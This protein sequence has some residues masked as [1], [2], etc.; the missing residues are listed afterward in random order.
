MLMQKSPFNHSA[1]NVRM[2]ELLVKRGE[3]CFDR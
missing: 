2:A 3:R 1:L